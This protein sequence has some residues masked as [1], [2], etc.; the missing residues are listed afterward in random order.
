MSKKWYNAISKTPKIGKVFEFKGLVSKLDPEIMIFVGKLDKGKLLTIL[1][2]IQYPYHS[3]LPGGLRT[4][5][6]ENLYESDAWRY[7]ADN[8]LMAYL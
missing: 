2:V 3:N 1:H 4:L 6:I 8:E 5:F 7:V